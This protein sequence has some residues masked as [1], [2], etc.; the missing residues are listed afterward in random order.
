MLYFTMIHPYFL[1]CNLI[2]GGAS[3]VALSRLIVL[4]KRAVRLITNSE[5][6]APSSPLFVRLSILKLPDLYKMQILL[7]MYKFKFNLLPESCSRH[8]THAI[9]DQHYNF[10]RVNEFQLVKFRSEIRKRST[11]VVGPDL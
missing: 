7:Y 9:N 4:Q 2:W 3:Q 8:V 10:R 6:R 11:A 5:Y 1:Y